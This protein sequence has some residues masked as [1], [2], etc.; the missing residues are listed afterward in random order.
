MGETLGNMCKDS[1]YCLNNEISKTEPKE[2]FSADLYLKKK[3][4]KKLNNLSISKRIT[5]SIHP[6]K[7]E[8]SLEEKMIVLNTNN[9]FHSNKDNSFNNSIS[10][11]IDSCVSEKIEYEDESE[12]KKSEIINKTEKKEIKLSKI[13]K[14]NFRKNLWNKKSIRSIKKFNRLLSSQIIQNDDDDEDEQVVNELIYFEGE[15]CVF[16]GELNQR[17]PLCGKGLLQLNNGAKLEG[18]FI[19][20]KLNKYGKYTDQNGTIFEGEFQNG[21]LNGKGKIIQLK[22][23]KNKSRS[24]D[25]LNTITYNGDIR[26]FKKEGYGEEIC[27]DYAYEGYFHNDKKHGKGKIKYIQT[28]D[29]YEGD[30]LDGLITGYG[31]YVW[32]NKCEYTGNFINGEMDG[33]GL[34]KWPDGCEYEGDYVK[35]IRKGIGKFTWSNGNSFKGVF[36]NGKP[37]GKGLVLCNGV[38]FKAEYKNGNFLEKSE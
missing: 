27:Q 10:L 14:I 35:G 5:G 32:S 1:S 11:S 17:E 20:G 9:T 26:D 18:Y 4:K 15:Q 21:V 12:E 38:S 29:K 30:F 24:C 13:D 16:N 36:K 31:K 25:I 19:N 22:Q 8:E 23:N 37:N 3:V 33:K 28:G 6:I 34:F 7:T 2:E